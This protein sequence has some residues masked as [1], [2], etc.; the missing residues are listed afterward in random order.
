MRNGTSITLS[1]ILSFVIGASSGA[2]LALDPGS[3]KAALSDYQVNE[4]LISEAAKDSEKTKEKEKSKETA[5]DKDKDKDKDKK[6]EA[7]EE[8]F[9]E[10]VITDAIDVTTDKLVDAPKNYMGKNIKFKSEFFAFSNLALNYK[11]ALRPQKKFISFLVYRPKSKV[12]FSELKL[13]MKIP[14]EKDPRNKMLSSL[15]DGD[16]IEVTGKVFST[17]LDEPW[18]DVLNL[19][20][21]ASAKKDK[22][23]DG[24]DNDSEN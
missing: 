20:K 7:E 4:V 10:P 16:T 22:D 12:P 9:K 23:K 3:N 2:A 1:L 6:A 24:E 21:L 15:Q 5:P 19:K 14:K 17:A 13:A 18:V 11:P 8:D